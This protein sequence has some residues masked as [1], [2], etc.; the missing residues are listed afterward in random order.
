MTAPMKLSKGVLRDT[1]AETIDMARVTLTTSDE[2]KT[3]ISRLWVENEKR[4]VRIGELLK[5]AQERLALE[6]AAWIAWVE[7]N[8]PFGRVAAHKLMTAADALKTGRVPPELAP[9]SY[10]TVYEITTLRDAERIKAIEDGVLTPRVRREDI[11]AFKK[12]Q[13]ASQKPAAV[14]REDVVKR[15]ERLQ[16]ELAEAQALL[17][18]IDAAD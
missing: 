10:T 6:G 12:R 9:P 4:F 7:G 1:R 13:R 2:F 8:L 14:R 5:E 3:E 17:E 15:I 11:V 16:R 18:A